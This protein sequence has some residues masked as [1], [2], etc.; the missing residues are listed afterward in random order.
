MDRTE[1]FYK[2]HQLLER[3]A[4]VRVDEFLDALGIS[5]A[6]FKRD[7]EYLRD[8]LNAPIEWDRA[9]RGYRYVAASPGTPRYEL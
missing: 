3:K 2:I 7:L 5:L 1:R 8:R 4:A 9:R 6:T